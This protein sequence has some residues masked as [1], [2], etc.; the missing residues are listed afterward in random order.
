MA[1]R[2]ELGTRL[3]E[4]LTEVPGPLSKDLAARL[5]RVESPN[6]TQLQ[7]ETPIFWRVARGA[8]VIDADDNLYID[9]TSGFGVAVSG[10][11]NPRVAAA[12]ADQA[13][14]LAHGMGDVYPPE[15]KVRLLERLSEIAP[16]DLSISILSSAGAEAVEAALK[17]ALIHTGRP[18]VIAFEGSYHGLTYGALAT[19]WHTFFREPFGSQLFEGVRFAPFPDP[20]HYE[21]GDD[22]VEESLRRVEEIIIEARSSPAPIGALIVEPIQGRGGIIVPPPEFHPQLRE[23]CDAHGVTLIYDEIYTGFGRTGRW[24][25][26][27]HWGVVPDLMTLGKGLTGMLPLSATVGKPEIMN[28]WPP[29]AGE[30]IHTS[31]FLG[32]PIA[33]A[34][35]LA[36]IDE[37]E[38]EDLVTRAARLGRE[39]T[40]QLEGWRERYPNVGDIRGLGLMLGIELVED[41]D[42]KEPATALARE[43]AGAALQRGIILLTQGP[44]GNIL[45][46]A[47]PLSIEEGQ[48]G[49]A[50]GVL[51]EEL[52]RA[53]G[54]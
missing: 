1:E 30:A 16:G 12:V 42:T 47:P 31:T 37:L 10:H 25:A 48:L 28:S 39:L 7:D 20:Y 27:E 38:T 3:P 14:T 6:I 23:L 29:S 9:L 43:I 21:G 35:A 36:Q 40:S 34:A 24:F 8:N 49:Y 5:S 41:P 19:T 11:A 15:V 45:A 33:C 22:P 2:E 26:A 51:E 13:A 17:T 4:I 18:G 32:N 44:D 50:I 46:L 54:E 52:V 53:T